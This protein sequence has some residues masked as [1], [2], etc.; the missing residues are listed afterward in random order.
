MSITAAVENGTIKLPVH[1]PDGT[2]V[3]ITVPEASAPEIATP[4]AEEAL[5][6]LYERLKELVG[7]IKDGP[8]D[9]AAEHES[10]RS[11]NSE[12]KWPV[13][14]SLPTASISFAQLQQRDAVHEKALSFASS[15]AGAG[16]LLAHVESTVGFLVV[17]DSDAAFDRG[18]ELYRSPL[19]KEWSLPDCISLVVTSDHGITEALNGRSPFRAGGLYGPAE[20]IPRLAL[21]RLL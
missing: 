12:T 17:H 13:S 20:M 14:L 5:P 15:R 2:Q 7:I 6:T 3:E 1:V 9:M 10:L 16:A 11:R 19:D 21:R 8:T 18:F 4:E